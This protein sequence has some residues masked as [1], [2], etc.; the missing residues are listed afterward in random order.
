MPCWTLWQ[1]KCF[2]SRSLFW[3][4][5]LKPENVTV[6]QYR[7][8]SCPN[9]QLKTDMIRSSSRNYALF[10][11]DLWGR[12]VRLWWQ[13][14][15]IYFNNVFLDPI[16]YYLSKLIY[17]HMRNIH[18]MNSDDN[19]LG[20]ELIQSHVYMCIFTSCAYSQQ[21]NLIT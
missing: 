1:W 14:M 12:E 6:C 7:H 15:R 4:Q 20:C 18:R 11:S 21:K 19:F 10:I 2:R 16:T 5:Q 3:R 9:Y 13:S 8:A 17:A